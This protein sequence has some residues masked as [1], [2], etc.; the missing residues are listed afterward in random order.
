MGLPPAPNNIFRSYGREKERFFNLLVRD[1]FII[2][3]GYLLMVDRSCLLLIK[4]FM[5]EE[6]RCHWREVLYL[7]IIIIIIILCYAKRISG[8]KW[9]VPGHLPA[10][11]L[12]I[13]KWHGRLNTRHNVNLEW[14]RVPRLRMSVRLYKCPDTTKPLLSWIW[15]CVGFRISIF[16]PTSRKWNGLLGPVLVARISVTMACTISF[17]MMDFSTSCGVWNFFFFLPRK[18]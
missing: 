16:R 9:L 4:A 2:V 14:V 7:K 3:G 10:K 12:L 15:H 13:L 1:I 8:M 5:K 17:L 6:R 18:T 11:K